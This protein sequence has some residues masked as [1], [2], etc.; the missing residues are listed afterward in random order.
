M[1]YSPWGC[2]ESDMTKC[3]HT[4]TRG[5][6]VPQP[7]IETV[8]PALQKELTT[9]PPGKSPDRIYKRERR[10]E[11]RRFCRQF[12]LHG[13]RVN[14][15]ADKEHRGLSWQLV[16]DEVILRWGIKERALL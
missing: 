6:L 3:T 11:R 2:K 10:E 4:H 1:G 7:G 13:F 15:L 16:L 8:S 14:S 9:G 12:W 5:I